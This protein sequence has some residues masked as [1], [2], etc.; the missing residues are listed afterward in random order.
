MPK[1]LH[2]SVLQTLRTWCGLCGAVSDQMAD[3]GFN[4]VPVFLL[5]CDTTHYIAPDMRQRQ[6]LHASLCYIFTK[7]VTAR[8]QLTEN[9][10]A[11]WV[12]LHINEHTI[13]KDSQTDRQTQTD[14]RMDG[15]LLF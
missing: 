5:S 1:H 9:M 8:P 15:Y 11:V 14:G 3:C 2:C 12:I 7:H 10:S 6:T 13:M 4:V